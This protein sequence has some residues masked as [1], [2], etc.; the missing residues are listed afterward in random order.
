MTGHVYQEGE[1]IEESKGLL[2]ILEKYLINDLKN[3]KLYDEKEIS[4]QKRVVEL[5]ETITKS[6]EKGLSVESFLKLV[7]RTR[8]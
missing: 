5:E 2:W 8:I 6:Q 3:C 7:K 4:L 1:I